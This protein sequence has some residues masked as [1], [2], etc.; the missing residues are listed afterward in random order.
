MYTKKQMYKND[1][2]EVLV[3]VSNPKSCFIQLL[4]LTRYDVEPN[5]DEKYYFK[6]EQFRW[7]DPRTWFVFDE[8]ERPVFNSN[9]RRT[10]RKVIKKADLLNS[11]HEQNKKKKESI[12]TTCSNIVDVHNRMKEM[13]TNNSG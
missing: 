12:L 1:N 9:Y 7:Y 6:Y 10:L 13:K 5:V 8:W 2:Y 11:Q 3:D 4:Q